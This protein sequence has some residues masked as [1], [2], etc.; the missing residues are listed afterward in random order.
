M[1]SHRQIRFA[2]GCSV[3]AVAAVTVGCGEDNNPPV[4]PA[5]TTTSAPTTT[6]AP[7][8]TAAPTTTTAPTTTAAPTTTTA[9]PMMVY[10]P[11]VTQLIADSAIVTLRNDGFEFATVFEPVSED[12]MDVGRVI[13]QDPEPFVEAA[14]G[15]VVTIYIGDAAPTTTT[16]APMMVYVPDVTQLIADSAIVTLRNDGFEFATVFEPVSED[17]MDV[18]RVIWQDPE[19]FVEAAW[20]SVVTIYI[21]DASAEATQLP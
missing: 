15:S 9:A 5:P 7:T 4:A 16:A 14:W 3:L 19:P 20:G 18:G 13:W 17:S 10:V 1:M 21:G 11:D 6:T 12:S 8:T 2:L